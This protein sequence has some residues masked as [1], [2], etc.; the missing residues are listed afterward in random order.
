MTTKDLTDQPPNRVWMHNS[1]GY[2]FSV[3]DECKEE[4]DVEY[5][6][7]DAHNKL[8]AAENEALVTTLNEIL[9]EAEFVGDAKE[10]FTTWVAEKVRAAIDLVE[11][12]ENL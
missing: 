2:W 11:S 7:A 4:G 12:K 5:V 9:K 8:T 10:P 3:A 6:R 1:L